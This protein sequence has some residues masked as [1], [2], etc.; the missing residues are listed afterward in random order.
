MVRGA[1]TALVEVK[2]LM[3]EQLARRQAAAGATGEHWSFAYAML[4][5]VS[6]SFALLIQQLTPAELRNAVRRRP[7]LPCPVLGRASFASVLI[8]R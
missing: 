5:R 7:A 4:R 8:Q 6:R 3:A 2:L 1:S